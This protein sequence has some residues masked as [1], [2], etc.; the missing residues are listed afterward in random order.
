M[1]DDADALKDFDVIVL[2]TG[3]KECILSGLLSS[4]AKKKVLQLDRN[5]YYGGESASLN[6]EQLVQKFRGPD[7]KY[8]GKFGKSNRFC[9]DLCPKFLMGCGK[10]V[11]IL[12]KTEV[13]HYLDFKSVSGSY[14]FKGGKIYKVPATAQEAMSS[15]LMGIFEKRRFK[16]FLQFVSDYEVAD[17]STHKGHDLNKMT[18]TQLYA[19]FSLDANTQAFTGHAIALFLDDNYLERPAIDLVNRTKLYFNSLTKY[20]NSPYI[21]PKYGLGGLPEGFSRRCAV[22]GGTFMLNMQNVNPFVEKIVYDDSGKVAGIQ[23]GDEVSKSY[24]IPKQINCKQ[25]IADPL[26]FQDTDK[27]KK[28]GAV[29]RCIAMFDQPVANTKNADSCQIIIPAKQ[30]NRK[31]DI[32]V[33]V[34]SYHHEIAPDGKYVAVMSTQV[35]GNPD[36]AESELAPALALLP[37]LVEK[38]VWVSDSYDAVGDGSNDNCY[39]TSSYDATTHFQTVSEEVLYWYEKVVGEPLDLSRSESE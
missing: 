17:P 30:V 18:A 38:F 32:Y 28:T 9:I 36:N 14:V 15:S 31:S 39:I 16:N 1:A 10:L 12:L 22:H 35:E 5:S 11:T 25:L 4:I 24:E 2:G 26:Y 6:M 34:V 21:Y 23:L 20:K 7:A 33:S 13:T 19:A 3:L 27:V 8:D 37:P 29:V